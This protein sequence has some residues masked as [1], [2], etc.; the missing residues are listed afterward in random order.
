MFHN[1]LA[2]G[3]VVLIILAL[4]FVPKRLPLLGRGVGEGIK[5]FKAGISGAAS[6]DEAG[7]PQLP[8]GS[9]AA[10]DG[11]AAPDRSS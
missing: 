6:P 7:Q 11:A 10:Q 9:D 1:P 4:F 8:E 2:D 3:I 5:E